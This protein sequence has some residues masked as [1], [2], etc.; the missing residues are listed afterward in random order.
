MVSE[1]TV[2]ERL[3]DLRINGDPSERTYCCG[4]RQIQLHIRGERESRE[5]AESILSMWLP[6]RP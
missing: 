4:R 3:P 6:V 5:Y 1:Q 2:K